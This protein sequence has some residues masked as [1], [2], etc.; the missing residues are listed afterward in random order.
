MLEVW[1]L[2]AKIEVAEGELVLD[3]PDDFPESLIDQLR[4]YKP[5]VIE[6][7]Q[8]NTA[9]DVGVSSA[10]QT[11]PGIWLECQNVTAVI[12]F[13]CGHNNWWCR[14]GRRWVCNVCHPET[15]KDTAN[16]FK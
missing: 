9:H 11:L 14:D 8:R 1:S 3:I 10:E 7:L 6:Y 4:R 12:C 15:P 16:Q 13:T 5:Q 2:D